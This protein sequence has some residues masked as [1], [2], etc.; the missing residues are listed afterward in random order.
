MPPA[1]TLHLR[2]ATL[3][4]LDT[5]RRWIT[6]PRVAEWWSDDP[7]EQLADLRGELTEGGATTY[8]IARWRETDVGLVFWYAIAAYAEYETELVDA[9]VAVPVGA[10]SMDYLIGETAAAGRGVGQ[11]M[12]RAAYAE[13]FA[14]EPTAQCLVIPV[15]AD[16]ERSWRLLE[17]VGFTRDPD[18][19]ELEPDNPAHDQRHVI[20]RLARP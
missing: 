6:D 10:W 9:G 12:L 17:R 20:S 14:N 7:E 11:A 8:R 3:A 2:P 1:N 16:N 13:L 19:V 4:D 18:L 15:H 5:I